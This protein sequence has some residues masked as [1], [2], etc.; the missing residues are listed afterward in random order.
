MLINVLFKGGGGH[1]MDS[2]FHKQYSRRK[3]GA[4]A[5]GEPS[6]G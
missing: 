2:Y 6:S 1:V 4:V 5:P 3:K